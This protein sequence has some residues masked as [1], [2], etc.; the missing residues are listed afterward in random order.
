MRAVQ[1]SGQTSHVLAAFA[2][3]HLAINSAEAP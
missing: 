2:P 3:D 1:F